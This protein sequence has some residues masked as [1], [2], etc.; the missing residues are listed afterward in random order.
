MSL[1]T[2]SPNT[3]IKSALINANF[4]GLADGSLIEPGAINFNH[5]SFNPVIAKVDTSTNSNI[6]TSYVEIASFDVDL[7]STDIYLEAKGTWNPNTNATEIELKITDD[8]ASVDVVEFLNNNESNET[9]L[10][11]PWLIFGDYTVPAIGARTFKV[12]A[13]TSTGTIDNL[14][15]TTLIIIQRVP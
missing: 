10:D 3:K 8:T 11:M 15:G 2:F 4:E 14:G 6:G 12:Y 9:N 13:K 7:D 1:N 5:L